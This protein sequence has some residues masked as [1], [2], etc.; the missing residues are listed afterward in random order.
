MESNP[1]VG[2]F[3]HWLGGFASGS[4][5]VPYK[6]VRAWSWETYWI[7]GGFFGWI[8]CPTLFSL[9]LTKDLFGVLAQQSSSTLAWTFVFGALWGVGAMTF[10]LTMRYLGLSLGMGIALGLCAAFGTLLPPLAK[11]VI[12]SIPGAET[13][14]DI[15]ATTSGRITLLGVGVCLGGI[16][17]TA[18]AGLSKE[19]HMPAREKSQ[20]IAEFNF[21]K[22]IVVA[23]VAGILSACFAFGL[24]AA[25]P[26]AEASAAAGTPT[27]WTGLP[28][29]VV[30]LVGGFATNAVW[31]AVLNRRNRTGHEYLAT[32]SPAAKEAPGAPIPR[33]ANYFWCAAS[34]TTWYLQFFFY[35][36][37]ETKIGAF[38]FASWTLHMASIIIFSTMWGWIFREWRGAGAKAHWQLALGIATLIGSTL[39]IGY[40]AYVKMR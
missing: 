11:S 14:G 37:G 31:C 30:M 25:A 12:P 6:R 22:G 24:T 8:V 7:V 35:T 17:I 2:V 4:F 20:S 16:A 18:L 40:G 38:A 36:I 28:K 13:L 21:S 1:F 19:R 10:G 26:I 5:Y 23:T 33:A 39:V 34:G 32:A 9:V 15:A 3:Y 27:T 29:L